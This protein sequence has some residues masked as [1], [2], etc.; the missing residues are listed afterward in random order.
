MEK[1]NFSAMI[2][3]IKKNSILFFQAKIKS[4]LHYYKI[5]LK[6]IYL[7]VQLNKVNVILWSSLGLVQR[8]AMTTYST[9]SIY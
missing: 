4:R 3:Q 6:H 1:I 7:F 8:L 9:L 2:R 5:V